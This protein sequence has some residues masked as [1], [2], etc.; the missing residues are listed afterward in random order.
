MS[1]TEFSWLPIETERLRL[2]DFRAEDEADVHLYGADP[3]VARF[4][5]W[6]PN[7]P[8][9]THDFLARTLAHQPILPRLEFGLA[10][11]HRALGQ[12]VGSAA[13]HLRHGPDRTAELGY[14]LRRDLWGQGV[15]SEAARALLALGFCTFGLHRIF[16]TC[17]A[18]NVGSYRVMEKIGMRREGLL[19]QDRQV[20]G[21][22]R[23]TYLYAMLAEE[24]RG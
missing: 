13:L 8:E 24:W 10:I 11:E 21:A 4:M 3:A 18:E 9:E 7:T 20:K 22:W 23:D 17:N 1:M 6:G 15:V 5:P 16:A 2:R 19:R 14:C 12:V